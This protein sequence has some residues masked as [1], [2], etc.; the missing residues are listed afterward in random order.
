MRMK[1]PTNP[2]CGANNKRRRERLLGQVRLVKPSQFLSRPNL[3]HPPDPGNLP[4]LP[5]LA[6]PPSPT[7]T[8]KRNRP[9][10]TSAIAR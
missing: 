6:D 3:P 8:E 2:S 10:R 9:K 1:A 4:N 5:N 7:R